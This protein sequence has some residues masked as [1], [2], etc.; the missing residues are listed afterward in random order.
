VGE[1]AGDAVG[2]A[3]GEAEGDALGVVDGGVLLVAGTVRS[4]VLSAPVPSGGP[5]PWSSSSEETIVESA[6]ATTTIP[7]SSTGT[8]T[9]VRG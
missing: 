4:K 3:V 1:L 9:A 7:A 2:D 5:A 8:R 6:I